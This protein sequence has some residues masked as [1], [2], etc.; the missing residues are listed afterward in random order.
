MAQITQLINRNGNGAVNQ[1]VIHE[2]NG[3]IAFQSY[4]SRVCEIRK[5]SQFD[6]IIVLGYDWDYSRTT[7]KHLCIFLEDNGFDL[8]SKADIEKALKHS[9]QYGY[10]ELNGKTVAMWVDNTMM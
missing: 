2:D 4:S 8:H 7:M 10:V 3:D 1:F 6:A 9:E 5:T